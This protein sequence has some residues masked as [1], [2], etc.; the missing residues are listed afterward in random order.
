VPRTARRPG[1]PGWTSTVTAPAPVAMPPAAPAPE[2]DRPVTAIGSAA[3]GVQA[4]FR[5]YVRGGDGAPPLEAGDGAV[6]SGTED[7][8]RFAVTAST[9]DP[10]TRRGEIA[11]RGWIRFNYPG[12]FFFITMK[13]PRLVVD[14]DHGTLEGEMRSDLF[15]QQG[16]LA[17]LR[18]AELDLSG[19][20]RTAG[21]NGAL[22]LSGVVPR[23]TAEAAEHFAGYWSAGQAL[24]PITV[25]LD[26]R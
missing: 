22:T 11:T 14:G 6:Y 15:G 20:T 5:S 4:F 3:W 24:D 10:D 1:T 26:A 8:F 18:I 9:Y 19:A 21:P 7:T 23:I 12:H 13:D 17:P 25:A 2:D 16:T